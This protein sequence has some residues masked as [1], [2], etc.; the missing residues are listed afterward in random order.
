MSTRDRWLMAICFLAIHIIWGSTYLAIHYA[1]E[2]IPPLI[3]AG[4]RHV[5]GGTALF[6]WCWSRGHRPTAEQWRASIVLG[7][8][9]FLIGHGAL[10]WAELFVPTGVAALLVATEPVW[11]VGL[12]SM[13]PAGSKLSR[14]GIAGLIIGIAA[15]ALLVRQPQLGIREFFGCVAIVGGAFSWSVG[16]IYSRSAPLH[17][18]AMMSAAMSLLCGGFL[19]LG[20]AVISGSVAHFRVAAVSIQSVEG[21]VYLAIFGSLTFAAYCW[22]L[23]RISPVL[24]ATH[25]YSNPIIAVILGAAI[26]GEQITPRIFGAAAAIPLSI[27]LVNL[28]TSPQ[29][30]RGHRGARRDLA[31]HRPAA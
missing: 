20:A 26:A 13:T 24:I 11:V 8:L 15:V 19:L 29:R 16:M 9:F 7:A 27:L 6:A 18:F 5:I 4:L 21:L 10:H 25:T 12:A 31:P 3:V 23:A 28:G 30:H 14:V 17:P 2:T 1:V 22:L